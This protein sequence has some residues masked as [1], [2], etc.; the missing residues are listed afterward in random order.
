MIGRMR[1][2]LL[3]ADFLLIVTL[4]AGGRRDAVAAATVTRLPHGVTIDL[5]TTFS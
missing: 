3:L 1:A 2:V 4:L 5:Q